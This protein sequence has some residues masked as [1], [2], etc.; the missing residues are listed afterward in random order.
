MGRQ[1]AG[2]KIG[3]IGYGGI[4][5]HLAGIVERWAWRFSSLIPL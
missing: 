2:S 5:R 4:G 1:L 3:I